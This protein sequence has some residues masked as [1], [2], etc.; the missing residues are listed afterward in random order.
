MDL[1]LMKNI[2]KIFDAIEDF[3]LKIAVGSLL[4]IMILI[5]GDTISRYVFNSPI[6]GL[7]E[8]I[9]EILMVAMVFLG[10]SAC[11]K[12]NEH[13][14]VEVF[15][16]FFTKKFISRI[17]KLFSFLSSILF[18]LITYKAWCLTLRAFT[19]NHYSPGS[20]SFP[21]APGY[22]LVVIGAGLIS[23]RLLLQIFL[24]LDDVED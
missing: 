17:N 8:F 18:A 10:I 24:S 3:F 14:R 19:N 22:M 9:T 12:K 4:L 2:Q 20:W 13:V 16:R 1:S 11:Q 6:V 5:S 21:L 15:L 7:T 23:V